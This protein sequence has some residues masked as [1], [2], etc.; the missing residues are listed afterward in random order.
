M[1]FVSTANSVTASRVRPHVSAVSWLSADIRDS[2]ID[3]DGVDID[4]TGVS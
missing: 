4:A 1:M 3:I 2:I